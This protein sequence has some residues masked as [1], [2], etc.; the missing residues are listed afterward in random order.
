MNI[1]ILGGTQF[2]G[3]AFVHQTTNAGHQI[4]LL[5]R[6]KE[7]PGLPPSVRRLI[8]DRDPKIGEGLGEIRALIDSGERFDAVVDMCGYVPRVVTESCELLKDHT[9]MYLFTS[10]ISVYPR[11]GNDASPDEDS[12]LIDLDDK[13]VE[14]VNGETY[15][16]LKVLCEQVVTKYFP[17]NSC[18]V[19]PTVIAGPNDP[20]DRITWWA[21]MLGTQERVIFP[22]DPCGLAGFIDARDLAEFFQHCI[23]QNIFGIFNAVGPEAELSLRSFIERTHKALGSKSELVEVDQARLE[24]LGVSPWTDIPTWIPE[25]GQSMYRISCKRAVDAGLKMRPLE[26]TMRD[27]RAWDIGRGEPELKA[28]MPGERMAETI[29]AV[30]AS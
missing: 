27:V 2:S 14:E 4:T 20:T 7:D 9:D 21:R 23:E 16:G 8:G 1:L 3:R 13:A 10:T 5:H 28:G 11:F 30:L 12:E 15:G 26:E 17:E 6:S 29:D 18:I 25:D 19:R 22:K 24:E